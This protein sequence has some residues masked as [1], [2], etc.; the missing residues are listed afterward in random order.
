MFL[1]G[2]IWMLILKE[3]IFAI[4]PLRLKNTITLKKKNYFLQG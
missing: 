2:K 4:L 1:Q 3:N